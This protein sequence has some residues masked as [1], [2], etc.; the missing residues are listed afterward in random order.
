[1]NERFGV[2]VA[3]LSSAVGGGAAVATRYLI[4]SADP[5]TLAAIRFG[6]GVLCLLPL[7]LL[8]RVRWPQRSDWPAVA[9]LGF[10]FFAVFFVLYNVALAYTTV[11]RGTLALSTLPLMTMV[12][13][14]MLRIE[15][16]SPRKTLGILLAMLGVA[17]ALVTGLT[18]APPGAW[19]GDL[20]MIGATLCM[21]LYNVWTRPFIQRSS[22]LGFVTASM[23]VGAAAL[24]VVSAFQGSGAMVARFAPDQWL[25]AIY[26]AAGGGA[27]AFFLLG[28]CPAIRKPEPR[29]QHHDGQS[30]RLRTPRGADP[31]R[32]AHGAVGRRTG[33][34]LHR[35]VD[36]D[37]RRRG[38][39]HAEGLTRAQRDG[40]PIG[41]ERREIRQRQHVGEGDEHQAP[42]AGLAADHRQRR[43][44]LRREHVPGE[45]RQRGGEAPFVGQRL[46]DLLGGFLAAFDRID[47]AER[48][49]P[50]P[51]ARPCRESARRRSA[52]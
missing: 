30:V 44:A 19:R 3:I 24:V 32:T 27:L 5:I 37:Y 40:D 11:A 17:V 21:A 46:A 50:R 52:S 33:H 20:I 22:A 43:G 29:R 26:L 12:V 7:A 38:Q 41:D 15:D 36:R 13:G 51:R 39:G 48:R 42:A 28:L 9:G 47:G 35:T 10:M 31:A 14:A 18:D 45:Q 4:T 8:L 16:L 23:G 1:M 2:G 49:R 6:G 34:R 25:A